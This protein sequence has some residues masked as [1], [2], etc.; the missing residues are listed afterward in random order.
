ML[1]YS[2]QLSRL[3]SRCC[4]S[5]ATLDVQ[6]TFAPGSFKNGQIGELEEAPPGAR[7]V[8][9]RTSTSLRPDGEMITR[10]RLRWQS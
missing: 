8:Q 10:G 1:S 3:W 2:L 5:S 4:R 6:V 9:A 7:P